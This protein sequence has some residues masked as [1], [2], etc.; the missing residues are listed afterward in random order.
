MNCEAVFVDPDG[1]RE[2]E[3]V[4]IGLEALPNGG[5]KL[6]AQVAVQVLGDNIVKVAATMADNAAKDV[7]VKIFVAK[8]IAVDLLKAG[9]ENLSDE[10]L[11]VMA[12]NFV[13]TCITHGGDLASK[14]HFAV[15]CNA[16]K[17]VI[18]SFNAAA[19]IQHAVARY[20]IRRDL[21]A[22]QAHKSHRLLSLLL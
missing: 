19:L 15:I 14:K 2:Q 7:G 8:D 3:H 21:K 13:D 18:I 10:Q 6:Q 11:E 4:P 1:T 17:A 12:T 5:H 20:L 16:L 22:R 9:D